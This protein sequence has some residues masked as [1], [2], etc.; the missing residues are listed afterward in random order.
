MMLRAFSTPQLPS[1]KSQD[2]HL[3][4]A[5]SLHSS[6]SSPN[7]PTVREKARSTFT[8]EELAIIS[9][10]YTVAA[11]NEKKSAYIPRLQQSLTDDLSDKHKVVL[12]AKIKSHASFKYESDDEQEDI[13]CDIYAALKVLEVKYPSSFGEMQNRA[14]GIAA[15]VKYGKRSYSRIDEPSSSEIFSEKNT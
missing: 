7:L 1:Q 2:L 11:H 6:N 4:R 3:T 12:E 15:E 5:P 8:E 9:H 14:Q 13:L 10:I